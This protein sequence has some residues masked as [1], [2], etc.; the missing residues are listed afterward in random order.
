[1]Q[2]TSGSADDRNFNICSSIKP[3]DTT[4]P[5]RDQQVTVH[6]THQTRAIIPVTADVMA[7]ASISLTQYEG[8]RFPVQLHVSD[9]MQKVVWGKD[10]EQPERPSHSIYGSRSRAAHSSHAFAGAF[11]GA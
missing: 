3:S 7:S 2:I 6:N 10:D 8:C 11:A 9:Q 1:M 5:L 4:R